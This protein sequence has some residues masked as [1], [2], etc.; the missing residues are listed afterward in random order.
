MEG[1]DGEK[2]RGQGMWDCLQSCVEGV[3][4]CIERPNC[5][6]L[7]MQHVIGL[8]SQRLMYLVNSACSTA[9]AFGEGFWSYGDLEVNH[10]S[11]ACDIVNTLALNFIFRGMM[12]SWTN[13][14]SDLAGIKQ[15]DEDMT[16]HIE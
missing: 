3:F 10:Q 8:G 1:I 6:V 7:V 5:V 14:E 9:T 13:I 16:M 11:H 15:A 2:S 4:R 12:R